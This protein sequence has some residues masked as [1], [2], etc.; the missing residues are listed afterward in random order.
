M[1]LGVLVVLALVSLGLIGFGV[2]SYNGLVSL[3]NRYRNAFEQIDVQL[4][5][6]Y[7]LIPNLVAVAKGYLKHEHETLVA[8]TRAR[9]AAVLA[10]DQARAAPGSASAMGALGAA[11]GALGSALGRLMV[12]TESYPELKAQTSMSDLSEELRSTENRV[13]FA[14][15]HY[16]D[17]VQSYDD[18][19][20]SFPSNVVANLFGFEAAA[21]LESISDPRE[22]QAP[23]V[24]L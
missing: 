8:V 17:A 15:Q 21:R 7:D 18:R 14:R 22:R 20:L 16:N 24:E 5:R 12:L 4:K 6:R 3:R 10:S 19:R 13:A 11:E 1:M 9:A 23:K 2:S